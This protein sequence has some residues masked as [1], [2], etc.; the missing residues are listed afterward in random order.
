MKNTTE[1]AKYSTALQ[2]LNTIQAAMSVTTIPQPSSNPSVTNSSDSLPSDDSH[3]TE[4]ILGG[5]LG[6]LCLVVIGVVILVSVLIVIG[7]KIRKRRKSS[8]NNQVDFGGKYNSTNY[9]SQ[10]SMTTKV[11]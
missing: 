7:R 5:V 4:E 3:P 6:V 9:S 2:I 8:A 1:L 10:V 11:I